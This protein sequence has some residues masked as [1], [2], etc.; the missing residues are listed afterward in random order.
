M[1]FLVDR[2]NLEGRSVLYPEGN[3]SLEQSTQGSGQRSD[4]AEGASG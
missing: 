2:G 4:R 3:Q 1:G